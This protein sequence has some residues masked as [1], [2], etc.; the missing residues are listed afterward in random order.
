MNWD[1]FIFSADY[2]R[3]RK[4]GVGPDL[5]PR[6]IQRPV[7]PEDP[8]KPVHIGLFSDQVEGREYVFYIPSTVKPSGNTVFIFCPA[9]KS[10]KE[11]FEEG[12]W[13]SAL[14]KF[15]AAGCF[16]APDDDWNTEDPGAE[17]EWFMKVYAQMRNM[18]FYA[19]NG[20]AL[21]AIGLGSGAY[22]A[23]VFS[24]LHS[25]VL[26]AFAVAGSCKMNEDLLN[27]I[28]SL[29]AE[30]DW[31][32]LKRHTPLPGWVLDE[33]GTG[34]LLADYLN[35]ACGTVQE[36][37]RNDVA[38]IRRQPPQR[39]L[40]LNEQSVSEVWYSSTEQLA[41]LSEPELV[42][43][44]LEFVTGYKRWA[45]T[46]NGHI[47]RTLMPED[48][49]LSLREITVDGLKRHWY[50]YEPSCLAHKE[51]ESYPLVV[52]IHGFSCSGVFFAEHSGWCA[53]AEARGLIV[54]FPT[55]YP[56]GRRPMRLMNP[57]SPTPA[58]NSSTVPDE[59]GPDDVAFITKLVEEMK[60]EYP[61]DP[62][63]V[64]ATGHSNG[65]A[66]TQQL[67]RHVPQL[68]AAFG[69]IG[70]MEARGT[71]NLPALPGDI[72]RPVW[73]MMGE[74]DVGD[75]DKLEE[76][77]TNMRTILNACS[78][79]KADFYSASKY[80]CGIY[81]HIVA[82]NGRTPLVRFTGVSGWPHTV[83]P[84]TSLMLYDE[85]F[86]KFRRSENGE[87]IYLG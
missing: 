35:T 7:D 36:N 5:P 79:N 78:K 81:N 53:V 4:A 72:I 55:A 63:R 38:S 43:R 39:T 24:L 9:G 20:D 59:N 3:M 1:H 86:C 37:L 69:P 31:K 27:K 32:H 71:D 2:D 51:K 48:M 60:A 45:G 50:V 70:S 65:S 56:F 13:Q 19:S 75:G 73:Y 16:V 10:A 66:M 15:Q 30:G 22:I 64:Y 47:R 58:W 11:C 52:A 74:F 23:S 18:E 83:S 54:A 57:I 44:M 87:S 14:T 34:Q 77:N 12:D 82:Y 21:Y 84:E 85:F 40:A 29:P 49:R 68:F 62:S 46:G 25:S 8:Y 6:V 41:S 76:G 28:G 42:C 61:I 33:D 67:L 80:E 26:A 17:L